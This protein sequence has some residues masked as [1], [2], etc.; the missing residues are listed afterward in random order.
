M[1]KNTVVLNRLADRR[2]DLLGYHRFLNNEKVTQDKLIE[3]MTAHCAKNV[4]GRDILCIQDTT[5]FNFQHHKDRIKTGELGP[6][7]NN[8]D[9]GFFA[10]PMLVID[11]QQEVCMGF[12]AIEMWH[13]DFDK[14]D[15]HEREYPTQPIEEKESYRWIKCI[16]ETR[17]NLQSANHITIISDRESDIYQ[18]WE[19]V[20]DKKTDLIIR[21]RGNRRLYDLPDSL[22]KYLDKQPSLGSYSLQV[23]ENKKAGRSKHEALLQLKSATVKI[24]RPVKV[25]NSTKEYVEITAVEVKEA[26]S[27]V[28]PG[29]PPVHWILLTTERARDFEQAKEIVRKYSIRWQI[30]QLFRISKHQGIDMESSQMETGKGLMKLSVL[31]LQVA[32]KILQLTQVRDNPGTISAAITFSPQQIALLT[33]LAGRFEGQ[34]EKQK[35]PFP[36][37]TLSWAAWTIARMGGWKGYRSQSTPGPITM[38]RGL[39]KFENIYEG[40][41]LMHEDV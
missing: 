38:Y 29:E 31:A 35:N 19:R 8:T 30:E 36:Y 18:L 28:K 6:V 5:E 7:G 1:E 2:K 11:A 16:E 12:G 27:T 13:R 10:H 21:C 26:E 34:T 41:K 25:K 22:F 40:W 14:L 39:V 23:S 15:K 9:I 37:N 17:R 24:K 33:V 32:M 20:P 3:L 4:S